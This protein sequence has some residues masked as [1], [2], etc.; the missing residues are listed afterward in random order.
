ML[1]GCKD[2]RISIFLIYIPNWRQRSIHRVFQRENNMYSEEKGLQSYIVPSSIVP[3]HLET[4]ILVSAIWTAC[5]NKMNLN[6][7][8]P[9]QCYFILYKKKNWC[10]IIKSQVESSGTLRDTFHYRVRAGRNRGTL[11]VK[12]LLFKIYSCSITKNWKH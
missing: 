11:C 4:S 9:C 2:V 3:I 7:Q 8:A 5:N 6:I 10:R 12:A 1:S